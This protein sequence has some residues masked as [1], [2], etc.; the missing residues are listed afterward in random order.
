MENISLHIIVASV[1]Q[2]GIIP[3]Y[4]WIIEAVGIIGIIINLIGL[5][6]KAN[7]LLTLEPKANLRQLPEDDQLYQSFLSL[8]RQPIDEAYKICLSQYQLL[9]VNQYLPK[10]FF[11]IG[12]TTVPITYWVSEWIIMNKWGDSILIIIGTIILPISWIIA[13]LT[14]VYSV[15][16]FGL[17]SSWL[18]YAVSL[19]GR[20]LLPDTLL[21]FSILIYFIGVCLIFIASNNQTKNQEHKSNGNSIFS[22]LVVSILIVFAL[23][24][25]RYFLPL[26]GSFTILLVIPAILM[27]CITDEVGCWALFLSIPLLITSAIVERYFLVFPNSLL[28]GCFIG[29]DFALFL[30]VLLSADQVKQL[31]DKVFLRFG[32]APTNYPSFPCQNCGNSMEYIDSSEIDS[33]LS[34]PQQIAR[35]IDSM[36]YF[37]WYCPQC[38][39]SAPAIH[40][41]GYIHS[42]RYNNSGTWFEDCPTCHE[43]TMVCSQ[44]LATES[45]SN[46]AGIK[47]KHQKF[48]VERECACC[49]LVDSYIA[50]KQ[51]VL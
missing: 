38:Y 16:L 32:I 4:I 44:T 5:L 30:N 50:S 11:S 2:Q 29:L 27:L 35:S 40:L 15:I 23:S 20:L 10:I 28:V 22:W 13:F 18:I 6:R 19:S 14:R 17:L 47:V 21:L 39:Q 24:A 31:L 26:V 8:E 43:L 1:M 37:A 7:Q 33:Y 48:N 49:N 25:I 45:I 36:Q 9:L 46:W 12:L 34:Y 42:K 41:R 3:F 51:I